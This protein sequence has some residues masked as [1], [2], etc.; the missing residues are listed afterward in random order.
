MKILCPSTFGVDLMGIPEW[1]VDAIRNQHLTKEYS[2]FKLWVDKLFEDNQISHQDREK[3]FLTYTNPNPQVSN[4]DLFDD[5]DGLTIIRDPPDLGPISGL[6]FNSWVTDIADKIRY[7][8]D[9]LVQLLDL[10]KVDVVRDI[11]ENALHILDGCNDPRGAGKSWKSIHNKQ[12]LVYGMVQ[13]GKTASM[14]SLI[15]LARDTGYR[16]FIILAGDK[17]SLRDQTQNRVN[18]AF[19]LDNGVN[20]EK[21]IHSPTFASDFKH[22]PGGYSANFRLHDRVSRNQ[23]WTTIIVIK[24]ETNH[25]NS[26]IDQL[27]DLDY[28]LKE[29]GL[30]MSELPCLIIDDEADYASQNTDPTGDGPT[31]H[32][33]LQKLRKAISHNCYLAY[34]ATPQACLS[35]DPNDPIGYPKDFWWHLEP[36]M[37]KEGENWRPVS[38]L[39]SWQVFWEYNEYLLHRMGRDEWPHHE[40]DSMGRSQGVWVPPVNDNYIGYHDNGKEEIEEIFLEEISEGIRDPPESIHK[41]MIDFMLTCGIK[42]WRKWNKNFSTDKEKPSRG[43]I[44]RSYPYHAMMIHLSLTKE[45]QEKIRTMVSKVWPD[46]VSSFRSFDV[47][48]SPD[49]H[50]FRERWRLQKERTEDFFNSSYLPFDEISY[51]IEK[52]IDIVEEPIKNHKSG[53]PYNYFKGKPWIY[54]LNS[55]DEGMELNYSEK[56]DKQIRTKKAAII[57]GGYILSRGLTIEGLSTTVFCRTQSLSMGDTNMQMGRWFGHKM[58]EI[59]LICIHMQDGSI[60]I[61]RQIAEADKFLRKQIKLSLQMNHSPLR[62]LL[63]FRNSPYFRSTSREKS[64][65]LVNTTGIGFSGHRRVLRN[66]DF[67]IESI[68]KNNSIL[69]DFEEEMDVYRNRDENIGHKRASIYQDVPLE[70]TIKLMNSFSCSHQGMNFKLYADYLEEWIEGFRNGTL[71]PPPPVNIA[72]FTNVGKRARVQKYTNFPSSP[73]QAR[74]EATLQFG[75]VVGGSN[76]DV[77]YLG[78]YFIDKDKHWH[79]NTINPSR[80]RNEDEPILILFYKL[81]PNYIRKT[82]YDKSIINSENPKGRVTQEIR[83][84]P[85]DPS[86][87]HVSL[88][89]ITFACSTPTNGPMY[90]VGRNIL[91]DPREAQQIGLEIVSKNKEGE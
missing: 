16:L 25:L 26:L 58:H 44:E 10:K 62:T 27:G 40:K 57:V 90:D 48:S 13:S 70:K 63:E 29:E 69:D 47:H 31:I 38:Y 8:D 56:A 84:Q 23:D 83:L 52:C 20:R 82:Y 41:A 59:D 14:L 81:D 6:P 15:S 61:F 19:N 17:S 85:S 55:S 65:F 11:Q 73:K 76:D 37:V 18:N 80:V 74:D 4:Q 3:I 39:G 60:E 49:S 28:E 7:N 36:Y 86:Y 66:P 50:P 77:S 12:G 32:N 78:D 43:E 2:Q 71:P 42:W 51:F 91:I 35:A 34:T 24:K 89:V 75:S 30:S 21:L 67:N 68:K 45:N 5:D 1:L 79:T 9:K 72:V 64:A 54:L 88:P 53:S 46:A 87:V 33:D 22:A